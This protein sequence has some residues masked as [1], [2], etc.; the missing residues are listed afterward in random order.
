VKSASVSVTVEGRKLSLSNLEKVLYPATGFTKAQVIDY[1]TRIGPVLLPHLRD[2]PLTLKRYPDGVDH[3]YFYEKDCPSHR[4]PWVATAPIW[5][6]S[7]HRTIRYCLA[8]E[9]PTLVWLANLASLELHPSL[10]L[11]GAADCPASIVFDLDPG[12]PAT[13]VEC[14]RVALWLRELFAAF[15]LELFA[16]TSG[17]KGMQVYLPLNTPTSY[18][19][20]KPFARA[21]AELLEKQH[22][23]AVVSNMKKEVRAGRVFIDWSQNDEHKTTVSVYSLRARERPTVS[24]PVTWDEVE[25]AAA[26]PESGALT[27]EAGEVLARVERHGDLFAP[28]LT[29]KQ[30]LPALAGVAS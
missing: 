14:C 8:N 1:Y 30:R 22:P 13:I 15:D 29:K 24:T 7:T 16:K 27:F 28:L 19:A 3:E 17:S 26:K 18:E 6:G 23:E 10:S 21:V 2:H 12:A 5:S 4:P 9:L 11:V 25:A 20:T